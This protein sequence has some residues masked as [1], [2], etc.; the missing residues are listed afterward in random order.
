MSHS[1]KS[2]QRSFRN[3][4]KVAIDIKQYDEALKQK[5]SQRQASSIIGTPRET[6]NYWRKRR[7]EIPLDQLSINF[8]ES[9]SGAD[10]LHRFV[11]A[12]QFVM[13]EIGGCGIRLV[14]LVLELTHLEHFVGSCYGTLRQRGKLL[15]E[16]I[17][18]FGEEECERL[19]KK[20]P[21]K[22]VS[23]AEDETFHPK[24]CLVAIAMPSN[25]ILVEE[26][27]E[28]RDAIS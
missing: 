7:D 4:Q 10:F 2:S 18:Q 15:E 17:V 11:T 1:L 23:I 8:F 25:F 9:P 27:S 12:V 13:T 5:K 21:Q 3:R 28:K 24:P 26:Y 14:A 6:I 19:S 16:T 22:K 20:M